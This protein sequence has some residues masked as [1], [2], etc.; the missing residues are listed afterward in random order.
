MLFNI[1]TRDTTTDAGAIDGAGFEIMLTQQATDR[2]AQ[3]IVVLFSK[4]RLLALCR[5]R[6]F[7]F[8]LGAGLFARAVAFTQATED[9]ARSD[10]CPFI[11]QNRIKNTVLMRRA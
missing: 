10:G 3:G 2:R 7:L 9:L 6:I 1:F 11:F 8:R 5:S 4:R